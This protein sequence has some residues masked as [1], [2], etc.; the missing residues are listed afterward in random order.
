[1]LIP[2]LAFALVLAI[3]LGAYWLFVV[4]PEQATDSAL[5]KRLGRPIAIHKEAAQVAREQGRMSDV[6]F[7]NRLLSSRSHLLEPLLR[8]IQQAGV[9]TTVG[10]MLLGTAC[11]LVLGILIGQAVA[12]AFWVGLLLGCCLSVFPYIYLNWKRNKRIQ[13]FEELFPEALDLM[14]RA[15]RAGHTFITA[16]GMVADELPEPIAPEF[17]ILHDQQN[18]G[19]PLNDALREFG[20]RVP[21]LTA[22]FF[23]TAILTQRESGGNLTEVLD[24]LAAVIR[25]RFNVM[26]QVKV[27]A[28]HG[29]MTGWTLVALPPALAV[30]L[31]VVSPKHF[32]SML[33]D[34]FGLQMIFAAIVLQIAGALIIRKIVNIEY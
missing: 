1:M 31:V 27:R 11:L 34:Q 13:R 7:L 30:V 10:V 32:D 19:M 5:R 8:L 4:R 3:V 12:G 14:S 22:R 17:K 2:G 21:L 15:M 23:V 9:K 16:I 29:K 20:V 24:N 25:D 33:Q 28:A 18:F 6:P 26:R